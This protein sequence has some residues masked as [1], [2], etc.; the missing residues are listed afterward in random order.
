MPAP[1]DRVRTV[2]VGVAII[3]VVASLAGYFAWRAGQE[4]QGPTA[5]ASSA[6]PTRD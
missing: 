6:P 2:L 3:G 4:A 5:P 1:N